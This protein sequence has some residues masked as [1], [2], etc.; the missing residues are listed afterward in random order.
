[1]RKPKSKYSIIRNMAITLIS[2]SV[3]LRVYMYINI[4]NGNN[5]NIAEIGSHSNT[6][7]SQETINHSSTSNFHTIILVVFVIGL[8]LLLYHSR[9]KEK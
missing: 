2:I 3:I 6:T 5:V 1:M 4:N 8:L 7:I 9:K